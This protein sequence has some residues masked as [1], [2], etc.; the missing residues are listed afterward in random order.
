LQE[1]GI[2][3]T[4]AAEGRL[5]TEIDCIVPAAGRSER[6]GGWKPHLA[7]GSSTIIET[8]VRNALDACSR[9]IL[10]TGYRAVELGWLFSGT[11]RVLVVENPEWELGMFSSLRRGVACAGSER[12]F[13]T[14]GDM[15][16]IT[17]PVYEA[18]FS[19]RNA[20]AVFPVFGVRRGHPV[21][22]NRRVRE[23]VLGADPAT[24]RMREIVERFAVTELAW[25]DD[26]IL[27]DI[28]T[29]EDYA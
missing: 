5:V 12:Y 27:R 14:L 28:D 2:A 9:V 29:R 16:W 8:V 17:P 13:V 23:A 20:D 1:H 6:M 10:V 22:F 21:L 15:P 11:P 24:G 26:S 7:F 3:D 19:C 25:E 18:L 4:I